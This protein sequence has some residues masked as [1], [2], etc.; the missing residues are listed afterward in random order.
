MPITCADLVVQQTVNPILHK[1]KVERI[2]LER[3]P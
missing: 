3:F 1:E 2:T